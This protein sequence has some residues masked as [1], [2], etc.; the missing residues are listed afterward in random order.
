MGESR[1]QDLKS[2]KL[3]V[4]IDVINAQTC[5]HPFCRYDFIVVGH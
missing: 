3:T 5:R 2:H 4:N 1:L